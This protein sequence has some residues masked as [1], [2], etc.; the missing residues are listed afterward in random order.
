GHLALDAEQLSE[1]GFTVSNVKYESMLGKKG[2]AYSVLRPAGKV[3]IEGDV[4]DATALI[5]YI[6]R[7]D[8]VEVVKYETGQ[9]FVK[10][11][12]Q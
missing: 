11:K 4:Y 10:R 5:G 1:E 12:N 6:D 7:G 9:L 2:I 8:E 3:R